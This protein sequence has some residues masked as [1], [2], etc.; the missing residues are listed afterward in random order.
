[1]LADKWTMTEGQRRKEEVVGM[2][3]IRELGRIIAA[4]GKG[5][6]KKATITNYGGNLGDSENVPMG[7][8][9]RF[10]RFHQISGVS[11]F[12]QIYSIL[13]A[14]HYRSSIPKGES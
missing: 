12:Y 5:A 8:I 4:S 9:W 7:A 2:A 6:S 14:Q 1:M 11:K 3:R 10:V 13:D